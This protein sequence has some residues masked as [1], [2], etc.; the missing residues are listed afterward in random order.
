[1]REKAE[2]DVRGS[3]SNSSGSGGEIVLETTRLWLRKYTPDD[4]DERAAMFAD[5]QTMRY[6]ARTKTRNETADWIEWNLHSYA[7]HGFGLWVVELKN[8]SEFAGECGLVV[9]VVDGAREVELGYSIK[10]S[11]WKQGLASEAAIVSRD[12]AF[13][14]LGL[15]RLI[16]I[17]HPDNLPSQYV[18][19]KVGL[20]H[21]KDAMLFGR[22]QRIYSVGAGQLNP[23]IPEGSEK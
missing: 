21:E 20:S 18:A 8:T 19:K 16:S 2:D 23:Q 15:R 7:Q 5:E 11:L 10:R 17:I 1:M 12:Y 13:E 4:V 22:P 6:Y 3:A 9:Q 14:V